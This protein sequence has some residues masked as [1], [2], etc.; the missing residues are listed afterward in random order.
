MN[1]IIFFVSVLSIAILHKGCSIHTGFFEKKLVLSKDKILFEKG[2]RYSLLSPNF[3]LDQTKTKIAIETFNQFIKEYP[4][5]SKVKEVYNLLYKLLNKIEKKDY[6]I[7]NYYFLIRK[8]QSS[9][10]YFQDFIKNFPKSYLKEDAM[11]KICICQHKL[12]NRKNFLKSYDEYI[13]NFPYSSN[14]KKLG[15]LYKKL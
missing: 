13:K 8:Y 1:R 12:S 3:D 14:V 15:I 4:D 7:A 9:L 11:Y 2:K 6:N 10:I 5:S